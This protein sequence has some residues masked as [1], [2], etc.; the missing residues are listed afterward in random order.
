[1]YDLVWKAEKLI[2]L[3]RNTDEPS[4]WLVCGESGTTDVCSGLREKVIQWST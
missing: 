3:R 4:S 1:M 2:R